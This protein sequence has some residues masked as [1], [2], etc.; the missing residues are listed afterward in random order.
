MKVVLLKVVRLQPPELAVSPR[1]AQRRFGAFLHHVA[2][3]AGQLQSAGPGHGKAFHRQHFAADGGVGQ[4]VDHAH[5]GGLFRLLP[6]IA[7]RAQILAQLLGRYG[8]DFSAF[9]Q[10]FHHGLADHLRQHTLQLANAG[11]PGVALDDGLEQ[12][13]VHADAAR[14]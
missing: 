4:S 1:P 7:G 9:V 6:G 14:F 5:G 12:L 2:Q 11:F 8:D 13:V 10:H 3:L